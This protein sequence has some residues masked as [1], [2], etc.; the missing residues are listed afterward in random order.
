M[1]LTLII[2]QERVLLS[3]LSHKQASS[4]GMTA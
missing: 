1:V 2:L 3:F 4:A